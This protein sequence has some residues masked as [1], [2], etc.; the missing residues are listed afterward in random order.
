M[1]T[2]QLTFTQDI[3]TALQIRKTLVINTTLLV[4]NTLNI[5]RRGWINTRLYINIIT[6]SIRKLKIKT[7]LVW[8]YQKIKT[9]WTEYTI[10]AN[11]FKINLMKDKAINYV[12]LLVRRKNLTLEWMNFWRETIH[13]DFPNVSW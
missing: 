6:C 7:S 8:I 3:N 12:K 2:Q 4:K 9:K 10:D 11:V 13:C 5:R 1:S